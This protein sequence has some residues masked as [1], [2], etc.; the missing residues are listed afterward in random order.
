MA[1]I[2]GVALMASN[3]LPMDFEFPRLTLF[4]VG[5]TTV[6]WSIRRPTWCA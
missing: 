3:I 5:G 6:M 2:V 1:A 4:C